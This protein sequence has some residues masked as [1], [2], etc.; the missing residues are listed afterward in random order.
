MLCTPVHPFVVRGAFGCS[1]HHHSGSSLSS[2]LH[3]N[4]QFEF[5]FRFTFDLKDIFRS[6]D[7]VLLM[8]YFF[9]LLVSGFCCDLINSDLF[10]R[11]L[12]TV[13]GGSY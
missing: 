9:N 5:V 8:R 12:F 3:E 1:R 4:K 2:D 6:V 13:Y 11:L 7:S 10:Y